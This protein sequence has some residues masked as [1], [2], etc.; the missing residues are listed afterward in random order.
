[1]IS[2]IV[3]VAALI[4]ALA[5]SA[6]PATPP[7]PEKQRMVALGIEHKTA[8]ALYDY[9]KSEA[10][11]GQTLTWRT[12]PDWTGIWTREASPLFWDPDQASPTALPT[13][14]RLLLPCFKPASR[15]C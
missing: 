4:A 15:R 5:A 13:T 9:F 14:R 11:G 6:Q 1:M 12:A 3:L 10:N 7:S 2:R 8:R